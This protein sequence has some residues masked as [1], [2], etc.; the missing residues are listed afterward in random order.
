MEAR[1]FVC[2]AATV[3]LGV[4]EDML[5]PTF[6]LMPGQACLPGSGV[7]HDSPLVGSLLW[8][9]ASTTPGPARSFLFFILFYLI[10]HRD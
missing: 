9:F 2:A 4:S 6:P 3:G 1:A 5:G 8:D 10:S 7:P